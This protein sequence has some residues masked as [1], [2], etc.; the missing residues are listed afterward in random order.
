MDS[1]GEDTCAAYPSLQYATESISS[2]GV[3]FAPLLS[4]IEKPIAYWSAP[5]GT[6]L[7][8]FGIAE[9][10]SLPS[11]A[12]IAV[13]QEKAEKINTEIQYT[14]PACGRPR[15]IGAARFD[16]RSVSD[17]HWKSLPQHWFFLPKQQLYSN[18]SGVWH[19]TVVGAEN[20][21]NLRTELSEEVTLPEISTTSS[22]PKEETWKSHVQSVVDAI[23]RQE[24]SKVV[25]AHRRHLTL[26]EPVRPEHL[27]VRLREQNP[28]SYVT[29]LQPAPDT[30][31]AAATPELLVERTADTVRSAAL[32][33]SQERGADEV[34][35]SQLSHELQGSAKNSHEHELV[36]DSITNRLQQQNGSVVI[37]DRSVQQFRGVQHLHTPI[38]AT[39][40]TTPHIID[41][42]AELHP[43]P[44]VGG[45]PRNA[46]LEKMQEAESFD[47]GWY[48][49]PIGWFDSA[50]NGSFAIG[51]RSALFAGRT[52]TAYAGA[53]IVAE[54]NPLSEWNELQ[55]KYEPICGLFEAD[56][57]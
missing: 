9:A 32:A 37:G 13:I 24:V 48:A 35:D 56:S 17:A 53:G 31:F 25:L 49:A 27:A 29:I 26:T 23:N 21:I 19:T 40:N 12:G 5:D 36:V 57:P 3:T 14:G 10:I 50:G 45:A 33:G 20:D 47:R 22:D 52:V 7:L 18:E 51:I 4:E 44:A 28:G 41:L 1:R 55:W 16:G 2:D 8:S 46:A 30:L 43:T 34:S 54:S 15:Y 42:V 6:E 11:S 39:F 38:S